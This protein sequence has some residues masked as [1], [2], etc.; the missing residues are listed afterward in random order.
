[1]RDATDSWNCYISA[2]QLGHPAR[3]VHRSSTG[4]HRHRRCRRCRAVDAM[5]WFL[6]SLKLIKRTPLRLPLP[7]ARNSTRYITRIYAPDMRPPTVRKIAP[8]MYSDTRPVVSGYKKG[9]RR[10]NKE[11]R[12]EAEL[13][14]RFLGVVC[15][16][17]FIVQRAIRRVG[18]HR[19]S[20]GEKD[21]ARGIRVV[22]SVKSVSRALITP[23]KL[24]TQ[25][26]GR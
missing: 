16:V 7:I 24:T 5:D 8:G 9:K 14:V 17:N 10:R 23:W 22:F 13:R 4:R 11:K 12:V 19:R 21:P 26:H 20:T 6:P 3:V 1:M 15:K 2:G 25:L 18:T